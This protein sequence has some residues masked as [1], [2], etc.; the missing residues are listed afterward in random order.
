MIKQLLA[1]TLAVSVLGA[2]AILGAVP[3]GAQAAEIPATAQVVFVGDSI[4][5]GG[6]TWDPGSHSFPIRWR[7]RVCG[8]SQS[9]RDR[10]RIVGNTGGCLVVSCGGLSALK[11]DF[12]TK[13]L[14]LV[15]A[16]TT[17]VVEIGVNDLFM[18]VTDQQYGAAYQQIMNLGIAAGVK[19]LIATIPP[20]TTLWA[21]HTAHNPQRMGM[22]SWLRSYYGAGNLFDID[23]GLRIGSSGDADPNYYYLQGVGDGLH[24]SSWG[25]VC[26]AD[27][28]DPGRII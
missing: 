12:Q 23:A 16:P 7:N 20:T 8:E 9:C 5:A 14:D 27:W 19:V 2:A 17:V 22:N 25:A 11:D 26:I 3:Q 28:L 1:A 24:P 10:V 13:I 6:G 18:D 4:T 15:P 21:W